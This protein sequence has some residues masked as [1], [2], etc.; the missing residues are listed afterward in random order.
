MRLKCLWVT[1]SLKT[2]A[3]HRYQSLEP[4]QWL[5][6][7]RGQALRTD[8]ILH[9]PGCFQAANVEYPVHRL[10]RYSASSPS[11]CCQGAPLL[12]CI[13]LKRKG[14][15]HWKKADSI[16]I[17]VI[18]LPVSSDKNIHGIEKLNL[19]VEFII[20]IPISGFI[21]MADKR[22]HMFKAKK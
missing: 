21:C 15:R 17:W 12:I 10:V 2:N 9:G 8:R 19:I 1:D 3:S 13:S 16:L 4:A 20:P 7:W 6:V 5:L 22:W 11:T 14:K 18:W